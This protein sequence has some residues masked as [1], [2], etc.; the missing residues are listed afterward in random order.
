MAC[1]GRF[2]VAFRGVREVQRETHERQG[3][4]QEGSLALTF[5]RPE[6]YDRLGETDRIDL[7][8]LAA[9]APGSMVRALIRHEDGTTTALSL[10][11]TYSAAQLEWFRAGSALNVIDA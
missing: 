3:H 8:D 5:E 4:L 9:M 6:D 2:G 1:G 10:R 11:H 7:C